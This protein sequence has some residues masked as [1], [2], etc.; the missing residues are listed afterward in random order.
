MKNSHEVS[1]RQHPDTRKQVVFDPCAPDNSGRESGRNDIM[2]IN[3]HLTDINPL[4]CGEQHCEP[5]YMYGPQMREYYLLHYISSGKGT[6]ITERGTYTLDKGQIFVIRPFEVTKY[7]ADKDQPWH[8]RWVG[9]TSTLD[10]SEIL[11][12]DVL[13]APECDYLFRLIMESEYMESSK[14]FF[15]CAKIFEILTLI[16]KKKHKET[17]KSKEYI[18][19]AKN[20]IEVNYQDP[21]LTVAQIADQINLDRCYFSTLFKKYMNKSPQAYLLDLRLSKA[22]ELIAFRGMTVGD[23]AT[24]CGYSDILNFSRMFKKKFNVPPSKFSKRELVQ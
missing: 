10:L 13:T 17:N 12:E 14:E 2:I 11:G 20:F 19:A 18:L 22:A 16:S 24:S 7:Q 23:A 1:S 9:F 8:Y 3:Q 5:G 21:E 6:F 15:I 4:S